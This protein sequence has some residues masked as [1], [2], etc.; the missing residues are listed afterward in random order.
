[1]ASLEDVHD[2]ISQVTDRRIKPLFKPGVKVA[3]IIRTPGHEGRE[4]IVTD[5]DLNEVRAVVI[6]RT[7]TGDLTA[8]PEVAP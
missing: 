1:M 4:V 3:V 2:V 5:D 8:I 6:R 7:A